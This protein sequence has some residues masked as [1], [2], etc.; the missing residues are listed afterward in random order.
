[1]FLPSL[2]PNGTWFDRCGSFQSV[3]SVKRYLRPEEPSIPLCADDDCGLEIEGIDLLSC[4]A[5]GCNSTVCNLP[6]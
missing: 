4:N 5:P 6:G 3:A 2:C 1:M